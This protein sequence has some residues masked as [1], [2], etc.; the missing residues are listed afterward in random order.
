MLLRNSI[1]NTKKF[2]RRT[3]NN[4]KSFFSSGYH[5]LPK[6]SPHHHFPYSSP[7]PLILM[8]THQS[9]SELEKLNTHQWDSSEKEKAERRSQ[10][11]E[12]YYHR[13]PVQKK[14]MKQIDKRDNERNMISHQK[15]RHEESPVRNLMVER[16]LRELEML[17]MGNVEYVLDIEEVL[18]YYSR[19]TCPAY[20]EIVDNFFMQIYS[21]FFASV[22]KLPPPNQ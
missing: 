21:E 19:L 20:L 11:K 22:S 8:D 15:G 9:N 7:S 12:E 13:S 2:F 6:T 18:H 5:R 4:F 16:R 1:S 3:L 14:K 10:E 17:D